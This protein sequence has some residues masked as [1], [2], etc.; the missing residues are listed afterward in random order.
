M[1]KFIQQIFGASATKK[2]NQLISWVDD[3]ADM[4][5]LSALQFATQQLVQF[6][7]PADGTD[8]LDLQQQYNLIVA[9]E[10][11]NH[12]R[13]EKL[14]T[15]F[16]SLE[17][18]KPELENSMCETC[19]NYCRQA[20]I[21]QLKIIEKIAEHHKTSQEQALKAEGDY[22]TQLL[23][24]TLQAAFNM[25]KWRLFGQANPPAKVWLQI[26]VLYRFSAQKMLL[27]NTVE[28]FSL[29]TST[30]LSAFFV[31]IYMLG[32]L[33]QACMQKFH[34]EIAARVMTALLTRARISDKYTP[35]HYL[36]FV[37]LEKDLP[38]K[39]MRDMQPFDTCRYWE[40]DELEKLLSVAIT[41][42][43]RGEIPHNLAM[44]KIDSA[45][46]LNQTLRILI[47]EWKKTG[48]VRQRRRFNREASS[49]TAK[50][51]AGIADI[52]NQV[53]QANQISGGLQNSA[54]LDE[55]LR[56]HTVLRTSNLS[57]ATSGTL[58]TWMITDES[59]HGMGARVNKYANILAR[60]D[61][62]IGLMIEDETTKIVI[63]MVRSVKPTQ[64]NQLRVGIEII[65]HHPK[66]VQ[67]KR[68][69]KNE[70][71][72][73]ASVKTDF[74][75]SFNTNKPSAQDIDFFAGIYLPIEAGLSD[76]SCLILPKINFRA[77]ADYSISLAGVVQNVQLG[78]PIESHDDWVKVAFPF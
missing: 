74:K 7:N 5:D 70:A 8:K 19:Y 58:D 13:L 53:N 11:L 41:V 59:P 65:S 1:K 20:Y 9:L 12:P 31:Q 75:E 78:E 46:K 77:N 23:A 69:D 56:L 34:I 71:F 73:A 16:S 22:L 62:L 18:M 47:Q 43:D 21:F 72:P 27:N 25:V 50:V 61:K 35:E 26:N 48:Y 29:G 49:K 63:G 6:I 51:N 15:Q 39:R 24:Q 64:G 4:S 42:S 66:W 55:R 52:C 38:A 2:T 3:L 36:F 76:A 33:A 44:A 28:L 40:L 14:S 32:Q 10:A 37:D 57:A 67:L 45:K 17:N 54:S 30:S 68:S 60:P